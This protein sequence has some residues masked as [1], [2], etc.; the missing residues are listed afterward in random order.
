MESDPEELLTLVLK[1]RRTT[2]P[3]DSWLL[4][5]ATTRQV[6]HSQLIEPGHVICRHR[7]LEEFSVHCAN[8]VAA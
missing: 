3:N 1:T 2:I 4:K 8:A 7:F 6:D 5:R